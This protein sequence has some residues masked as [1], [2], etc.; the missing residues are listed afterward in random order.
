MIHSTLFYRIGL[1]DLPNCLRFQLLLASSILSISFCDQ[2][3]PLT[4]AASHFL[5]QSA[6]NTVANSIMPEFYVTSP[7]LY[8]VINAT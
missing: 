5:S 4:R 8:V 2:I 7:F 1:Y 3:S 6:F